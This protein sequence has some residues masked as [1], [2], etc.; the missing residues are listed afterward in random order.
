MKSKRVNGAAKRRT[1]KAQPRRASAIGSASFAGLHPWWKIANE[2]RSE[3]IGRK[4]NPL[5]RPLTEIETLELKQLQELARAARE[6]AKL[7]GW[8]K[9]RKRKKSSKARTQ[10]DK[11]TP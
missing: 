3:L 11:L 9:G 1:A 4:H 7:G 5:A 2:R 8:P 10:N 6:N